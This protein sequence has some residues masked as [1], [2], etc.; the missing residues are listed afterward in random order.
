MTDLVGPPPPPG[1]KFHAVFRKKNWPNG[2]LAPPPFET[3]LDPPLI[4]DH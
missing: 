4:Y 1:P 3:I 2:M